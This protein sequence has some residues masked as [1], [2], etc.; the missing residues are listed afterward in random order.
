M[1]PAVMGEAMLGA[2]AVVAP[3]KR[4]AKLC[5]ERPRREGTGYKLSLG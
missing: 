4:H 3:V 2:A 5:H 1:G